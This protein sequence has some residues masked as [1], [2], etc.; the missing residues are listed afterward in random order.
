MNLFQHG[1]DV[2]HHLLITAEDW[3]T[4]I[5]KIVESILDQFALPIIINQ[6]TM[7]QCHGTKVTDQESLIAALHTIFESKN[8]GIS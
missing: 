4:D 3:Y 2:P 6:M 7:L 8:H 5:K 1:I